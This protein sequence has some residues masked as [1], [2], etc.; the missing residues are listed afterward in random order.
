MGSCSRSGLMHLLSRIGTSSVETNPSGGAL[1]QHLGPGFLGKPGENIPG[2]RREWKGRV[3]LLALVKE[4]PFPVA[5][6]PRRVAGGVGRGILASCR[7]LMRMGL[8]GDEVNWCQLFF[9]F[10]AFGLAGQLQS[11]SSS[12]C[13]QSGV[14]WK[15]KDP[16][17][18]KLLLLHCRGC[19]GAPPASFLRAAPS[20][21]L[22]PPQPGLQRLL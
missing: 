6:S 16:K 11:C 13:C 1:G 4:T 9:I 5:F 8:I 10:V 12:W 18:S 2:E 21:R 14:C 7:W 3:L 20:T 19:F 15:K 22:W 17:R